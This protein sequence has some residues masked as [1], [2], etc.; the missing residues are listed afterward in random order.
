M[1]DALKL[2][3]FKFYVRHCRQVL[4]RT[5]CVY[6]RIRSIV[7]ESP[8]V[9]KISAQRFFFLPPSLSEAISSIEVTL[10]PIRDNEIRVLILYLISFALSDVLNIVLLAYPSLI[11]N[12]H[13]FCSD[14]ENNTGQL[15]SFSSIQI[16][17]KSLSTRKAMGSFLTI[18]EVSFLLSFRWE[19]LAPPTIL[20][21]QL[22]GSGFFHT[23]H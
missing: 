3:C 10:E 4:H 13:V 9:S 8:R 11:V 1:T 14:I 6:A 16:R 15:I 7:F 22:T 21:S 12:L 18:H 23:K 5:R 2:N 17:K 19:L 20:I